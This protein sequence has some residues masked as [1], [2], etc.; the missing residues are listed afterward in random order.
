VLVLNDI[1]TPE[2][3]KKIEDFKKRLTTPGNLDYDMYRSKSPKKDAILEWAKNLEILHERGEIKEPLTEI[4][5]IIRHDLKQLGLDN[6]IHYAHEVL[7]HVYKNPK[8]THNYDSLDLETDRVVE[9]PDNSSK[10]KEDVEKLNKL[11]LARITRTIKSLQEFSKLLKKDVIFE[12]E[13]PENELT[14]IFLNWDS[15]ID[16]FEQSLDRREKIT[17]STHHLLFYAGTSETLSNIYEVYVQYVK[18][19]ASVTPKQVG[20]ILKGRTKKVAELYNPKSQ[21]EAMEM[22]FFGSQCKECG[23]WRMELRFIEKPTGKKDSEGKPILK[24][25]RKSYCF[26]CGHNQKPNT[27]YYRNE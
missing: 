2:I 3:Y 11:T 15:V 14:E 7:P 26:K 13:I 8:F 1:S 5:T 21:H 4:S 25:E 27:E 12:T 20:K 17:P 22:G 18:D 23:S 19:F 24:A 16:H 9:P 10:L 6:L